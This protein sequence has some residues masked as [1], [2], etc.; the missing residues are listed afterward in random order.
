MVGDGQP[1]SRPGKGLVGHHD[2]AVTAMMERTGH[3]LLDCGHAHRL[4]TI[5][6]LNENFSGLLAVHT[7]CRSLNDRESDLALA[8][9]ALVMLDCGIGGFAGLIAL[10]WLERR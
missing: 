2:R 9:G 6:R 3:D 1:A 7:A 8:G 10:R 5:E 4:R